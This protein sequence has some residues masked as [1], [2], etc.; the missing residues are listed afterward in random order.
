MSYRWCFLQVMALAL[1]LSAMSLPVAAQEEPR[2]GDAT[3]F[4]YHHFGDDRYPTT[5][6]SMEQF[7]EQMAYLADND[8]NV[9]ALA[10]LVG[11]LRDG[12][13]LPPRTVV[14]T[15][16]DGYRTTYTKAWPVLQQYDFPFTVFLYVEGLEKKYSNYMTWEQVA[17]MAA[18]GVD[19]QD[20]SYSHHRLADW[21]ADWSEER[22]RR[23]ISEDLHRGKEILTRRLGEEP[24]F[25][26]IPYGEYNHIVLEEAQKI[27]YE[28]IF[29]QDAGSVSDDTELSMISREP[30]LGTNWSTLEHFQQVLA[31]V[32]LPFTDKTPGLQPLQDNPPP[33]IGARLLYP[34]RYRPG[35]FGIFVSELGWQQA[36]VDGDFVYIDNDTVLE[37]RINRVM[38]SA[39]EKDTGRTA[40]RFWMLTQPR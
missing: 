15:V 39:R 27:G 31:R 4:I 37:R 21:P 2:R 6:V 3:I 13:P 14:I 10:E 35:T 1:V 25:F 26:A 24:R 28:A 5:N 23:W 11:M 8:Y 7:K 12:T 18:A 22:Y 32:D 34:E 33:R 30:I 9:I 19:F 29:T 16:D 36:K 20:H 38:I 17:E 40:L